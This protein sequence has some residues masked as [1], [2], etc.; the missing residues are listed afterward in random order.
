MAK[1]FGK[2]LD[3]KTLWDKI[4]SALAAACAETRGGDVETFLCCCLE[5]VKAKPAQVARFEPYL[6]LFATVSTWPE[7]MRT[8]FVDYIERHPFAVLPRGRQRWE[9]YKA[10]A[11]ATR[12]SGGRATDGGD[13]EAEEIQSWGDEG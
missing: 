1:H 11:L 3:R 9:E 13:D 2:E 4:A 12:G 5:Q 8:A 6:Q 10:L 7:A